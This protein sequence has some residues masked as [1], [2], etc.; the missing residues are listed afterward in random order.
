MA[1][2][3]ASDLGEFGL[4]QGGESRFALLG[5]I[6]GMAAGALVWNRALA[7]PLGVLAIATSMRGIY[8]VATYAARGR[9][10]A[11]AGLAL[12]ILAPIAATLWQAHRDGTIQFD[13]IGNIFFHAKTYFVAW[14]PMLREGIANTL[15]LAVFSEGV[16]LAFG[17]IIA[18]FALAPSMV[19]RVIAKGYVD[20]LRG[21]PLLVQ[22]FVV[23]TG[24]ALIGLRFE[25]FTAGVIALSLNS[26][27][28]NAEIFRAGIQSVE[29]GQSDAA[30]SL[31]MPRSQTM[32]FVVI[33]QAVRRV[34]PPLMNEFIALLKDTS[35]VAFLGFVI[36]QRDILGVARSVG[37]T[38]GN[39][40]PYVMAAAA[41]LLLTIPLTRMV[42][43]LERRLRR[44]LT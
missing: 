37:T 4:E 6:L 42:D 15:K 17:L 19:L 38:F 22:L 11:R 23:Y 2:A 41:Y 26:A 7:I 12:G 3:S 44:G 35:L 5:G 21:S 29:R 25:V 39:A 18:T 36:G 27:A 28:Y 1:V 43:R 24:L 8:E 32:L 30:R 33:P 40:T 31:G 13:L 9:V 34:I 14:R 10:W 20:V 16:G